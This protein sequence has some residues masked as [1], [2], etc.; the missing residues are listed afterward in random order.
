[1]CIEPT[2][3]AMCTV[4][5]PVLYQALQPTK[6]EVLDLYIKVERTPESLQLCF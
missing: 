6:T 4:I 1:M 5:G 2:V 3:H